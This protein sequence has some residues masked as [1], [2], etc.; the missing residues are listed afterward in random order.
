MEKEVTLRRAV[1]EKLITGNAEMLA[2]VHPADK[3]LVMYYKGKLDLLR[4]LLT[5]FEED[6]EDNVCHLN[7]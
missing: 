4:A 6:E 2:Q 3:E 5:L 7:K 1:I